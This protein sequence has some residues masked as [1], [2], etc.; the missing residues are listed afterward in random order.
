[1]GF[2]EK[3]FAFGHR[4]FKKFNAEPKPLHYEQRVDLREIEPR[5][6]IIAKSLCGEPIEILEAEKIGGFSGVHFYYPK[7]LCP[8]DSKKMNELLYIQR[9]LFYSSAKQLG[10]CLPPKELSE[11]EK[12]VYSCLALYQ[13]YQHI[14]VEYPG[15]AKVTETLCEYTQNELKSLPT[16]DRETQN[17]VL[18]QWILDILSR[19]FSTSLWKGVICTTHKSPLSFW[20]FADSVYK[21]YLA[22]LPPGPPLADEAFILWGYL[23]SPSSSLKELNSLENEG[24][25][26]ESLANGTEIQGKNRESVTEVSLE[27]KEDEA[28]PVMHSFEKMET[29]EE[30]QGGL[31][32]QDGDDDLAEHAEALEELNIREVIRSRERTSS[33]YKADIRLNASAPDL[34]KGQDV[35]VPSRDIHYYP[36]W[37]Y[38]HK[39]YKNNWCRVEVESSSCDSAEF[40]LNE[41]YLKEKRDILKL[42]EQVRHKPLWKKRQPDGGEIDLDALV[43]WRATLKSGHT[44]EDRFYLRSNK[45]K[46]DWQ[47]LFLIDSSLSTDSWVAN[48]RILDVIKNS[49]CLVAE[50]LPKEEAC[51]SVAAFH[52]NTRHQCVYHEL[53]GFRD[54]WHQLKKELNILEPVGYTRIGPALRHA[55]ELHKKSSARHKFIILL[56]DGKASDYDQY[57]GQYG[58][59]D[60]KQALR[61]AQQQ[62]V[63]IKCLAIE[64][65]AKFYLPQMFGNSNIHILSNPHKLPQA[66]T[67]LLLPLL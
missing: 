9:T 58:M 1:M 10:L 38:K 50:A 19:N 56:S 40:Q 48:E 15:T 22:H 35:E 39:K 34:L 5:L 21:E 63:H 29:L 4:L 53:K 32:T 16:Q 36:E 7:S 28:N 51:V 55:L 66:L 64:E 67:E 49:V 47:V 44:S 3:L 57:E 12:K 59:E 43:D 23:M 61:E 45:H 30:Y 27:N 54:S 25:A 26:P 33:I 6:H 31:R 2:D 46:K 8:F 13:I 17:G 52:S 62:G 37:D 65:K 11:I 14:Q 24:V 20:K 42:F 60:I 18:A 41:T